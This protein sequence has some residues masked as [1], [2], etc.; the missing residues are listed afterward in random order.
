VKKGRN[1]MS[2]NSNNSNMLKVALGDARLTNSM[3]ESE[4]RVAEI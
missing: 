1:G 3:S 2:V 4:I